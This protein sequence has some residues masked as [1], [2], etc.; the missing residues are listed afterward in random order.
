MKDNFEMSMIGEMKFFSGL[1]V[2]QSL[3]RIFINQSQHTLELLKKHGME[4]CDPIS[5]LMATARIDADLQGM[6]ILDNL[7]T[8]NIRE[9][10]E[11]KD[12]VKKFVGVDVLTI[13]PQPVE[14]IQGTHRT[15]RV[16]RT[17]NPVDDVVQKK[18][19]K[20]AASNDVSSEVLES[21]MVEFSTP[22]DYHSI[23]DDVPLVSVYTTG[24][25]IVK[26]MPILDNLLTD[27]ICETQEYKD[28]VKKFVRVDVLTIQPQ[29]VE[30]IQGTH[31]T[32]RATRTPN[33]VDDVVQKKKGKRAAGE[34]SS[35]RPSLKIHVRHQ[36]PISTTPIPPVESTQGTHTTPRATRKPNLV[37]DIIQKK[38]GKHVAGE[39]SSP[40]PFL[41]IY[42][43]QQNLF[44]LL[45][46]IQ[47]MIEKEMTLLKQLF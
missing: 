36:K 19:G 42:D 41:K 43:R 24:N 7:L 14:S 17:P 21:S 26:G 10:Q 18:K 32:P 35:P 31:R 29:P 4:K 11:Y 16:T 6:P 23:K 46:H 37:D 3:R 30:S 13:Q 1:Q 28:Y 9:T 45:L 15:P 12:Y 5:T 8:D 2:H 47:V 34:T 38:K 44:P 25:V 33:P 27:N 40:R 20:R 39:T 22:Q